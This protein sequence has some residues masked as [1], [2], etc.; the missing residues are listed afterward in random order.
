MGGEVSHHV[1]TSGSSHI[2]IDALACVVAFHDYLAKRG[3]SSEIVLTPEP[4]STVPPMI[5]TLPMAWTS[6]RQWERPQCGCRYTV[7]D[8]SNPEF[9]DPV[10]DLADVQSVYDHHHGFEAYWAAR[11]NVHAYIEPVGACA[12]LVWE[13]ICRAGYGDALD[14]AS[15]KVLLTAIVSN[16][17]DFRSRISCVRDEQAYRALVGRAHVGDAWKAAYFEEVSVSILADPIE[18]LRRDCKRM[19]LGGRTLWV[20]QIEVWDARQMLGPPDCD[21]ITNLLAKEGPGFANVVSISE[22]VNYLIADSVN[23]ASYLG[24]VLSGEAV[25]SC[26]HR[27]N[28]LWLRKEIAKKF[29]ACF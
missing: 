8:V 28:A 16:T 7:M 9:F 18:A 12:T 24:N 21:A 13:Q 2:D 11:E 4:N 14:D 19:S 29:S 22:G 26:V 3:E 20:G 1:V 10:A 17:L 23:T 6:G 25:A 5:R 27:T 15:Y